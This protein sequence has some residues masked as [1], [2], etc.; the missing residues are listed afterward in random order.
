MK[1]HLIRLDYQKKQTLGFYH[2]YDGLEHKGTFNC[3]ELP[4]LNNQRSISCIPEGEYKVLKR[5]T[6]K[7]GFHFHI[8]DV[9]H[10]TWILIH[11]GNYKHDIQGCQLP[12]LGFSDINKD[13]WLDV[14]SSTKA[15][16]KMVDILP[17]E[18]QL[19]IRS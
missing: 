19:T 8:I 10:R 15:L 7:R 9:P 13:G 17:D 16:K 11:K 1:L 12:G 3:L 2:I 6:D 14:Y 4:W 18:F 5:Y